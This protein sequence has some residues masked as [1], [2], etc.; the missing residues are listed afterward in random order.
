MLTAREACALAT[1]LTPED[2]SA[3]KH[4]E[5]RIW[6]QIQYGGTY[7]IHAGELSNNVIAAMRALGYTVAEMSTDQGV[8]LY[9]I[10]WEDKGKRHG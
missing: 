8:M 5:V 7:I 4:L 3:Q 1:L 9:R 10:S 6:E 2:F